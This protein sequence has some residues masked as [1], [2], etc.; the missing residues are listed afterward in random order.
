MTVA[1]AST[2]I[3]DLP[4]TLMPEAIAPAWSSRAPSVSLPMVVLRSVEVPSTT[5][6]MPRAIA[7]VNA[8]VLPMTVMEPS[9][10]TFVAAASAEANAV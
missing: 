1:P 2:T 6:V 10:L 5:R 3:A 8:T 7:L 9:L 4:E